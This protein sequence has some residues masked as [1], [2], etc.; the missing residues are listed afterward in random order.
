MCVAL[1][2][3]TVFVPVDDAFTDN[4]KDIQ[5]ALGVSVLA[6]ADDPRAAARV[7]LSLA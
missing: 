4:A 6:L 5:E 1:R 2:S 3:G 7:S